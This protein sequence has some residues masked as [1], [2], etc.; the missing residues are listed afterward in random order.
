MINLTS[1]LED[2]SDRTCR[3][4]SE[5]LKRRPQK[6]QGCTIAELEKKSAMVRIGENKYKKMGKCNSFETLEHNV[7]A[8]EKKS[9]APEHRPPFLR[10][11]K[12]PTVDKT[13]TVKEERTNANIRKERK[14]LETKE[15][16]TAGEELKVAGI[17]Q[18]QKRGVGEEK[19][20]EATEHA[21]TLSSRDRFPTADKTITPK[22]EKTKAN[23]RKERK[24]LETKKKPT[25]GGEPKEAGIK[26]AEK[27]VLEEKNEATEHAPILSSRDRFPTAD[28]TIR[29]KEEKTKANIRKERK[30]L[31]TKKKPTA[32][33]EPKEAGI[34]Q[35]EKRVL[36]EKNEATEH[37]PILSSRDRFPTTD[38]TIRAKEEK[39]KANISKERKRLETKKKPTAGGEPKEAGIKQAEKRGEE[40]KSEATE[41]A[42]TFSSRDRF[43]TADK[44]IRAKEE[45]TKA[46]ISK[47]RKRLETK[48]PTAGGELKVVGIKQVQN[49]GVGEEKKS[50]ATEHAPTLSSRDRFPTADKTITPKEEKTKANIRRERKRLETK[51]KSTA[52]GELKVAGIKQAQNGGVGVEKKS[53]ATEHAPTLSSRDRFPTADKTIRAKEEKTK[54]N[55]SKERKRL[56]TKKKPTGGEE[57]KVVGIKQDQNGG[58][59]METKATEHAPTLSSRDRFPTADKTIRAK[60]EKTRAKFD[61]E[62]KRLETRKNLTAVRQL[63]EKRMKLREKQNQVPIY[64]ITELPPLPHHVCYTAD[65]AC[66]DESRHENPRWYLDS[67]FKQQELVQAGTGD[68]L[69]NTFYCRRAMTP[70]LRE[71]FG[72]IDERKLKRTSSAHWRIPPRYTLMPAVNRL[73]YVEDEKDDQDDED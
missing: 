32:G 18:T 4:L 35:A 1:F 6:Y 19:K 61:E 42:P 73:S 37:A 57:P 20:S 54:A 29:A 30:R 72:S 25:A 28:K 31:E 52:G 15:K 38:K 48:K 56:E 27:R 11:R 68:T 40:K 43:P 65:D 44:T 16:P 62:R 69:K 53:E 47:E 50:E 10:R 66:D 46:N 60:E 12:P 67:N 58:G 7:S 17:K 71:I 5:A 70:D 2:L 13:I 39:T 64:M 45:K 26:Q 41:H 49:G 55:I 24:R 51:K 22:E 36:E 3:G 23:I 14:R 8:E 9:E 33:G 34:K 21:P 59:L 63:Q